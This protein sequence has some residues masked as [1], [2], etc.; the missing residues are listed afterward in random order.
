MEKREILTLGRIGINNVRL[1]KDFHGFVLIL[2]IID[3]LNRELF[4]PEFSIVFIPLLFSLFKIRYTAIII[5]SNSP[6][7]SLDHMTKHICF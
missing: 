5:L 7:L 2:E 1:F 3:I 6:V 4:S